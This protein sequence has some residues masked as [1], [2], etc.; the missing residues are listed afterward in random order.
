MR[1]PTDNKGKENANFCVLGVTIAFL[2]NSEFNTIMNVLIVII[3]TGRGEYLSSSHN[4]V[5][6]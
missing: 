3:L 5:R 6:I 1:C 2:P 4:N